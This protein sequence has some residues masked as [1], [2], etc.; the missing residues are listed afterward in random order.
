MRALNLGDADAPFG[1]ATHPY[2]G[3]PG[4]SVDDLVLTVPAS[5]WTEV[6]ANL[7]PVAVHDVE[8]GPNDFR[9]GAPLA[10]VRLDMAF[11]DRIDAAPARITGPAGTVEMWADASF[12]WWQVYTSDYFPE[13]SPRRRSTVAL[14]PMTCGPN[15]FNSGRDVVVLAP[16]QD[17]SGEWGVR[18]LPTESA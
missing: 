10:D 6:D 11:C 16:G 14:E 18:Y 7:H 12:G 17:W 15:A 3:V 13:G 5:S 2:V 8:G 4:A 9:T 1:I